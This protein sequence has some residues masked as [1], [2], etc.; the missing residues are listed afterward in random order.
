MPQVYD[1]EGNIFSASEP[2]NVE[3]AVYLGTTVPVYSGSINT[4]LRY[5]NWELAAQFLFEGGHKMRNTNVAALNIDSYYTNMGI[6]PVSKNIENRWKQPG[7]ET[8]T[9]VPRF[10]SSES[11][12]YNYYAYNLY[13]RS[14]VNV[15]N[16]ANWRMKNLSVAYRLPAD[17]CKKLALQEARIMFGMENLFTTAKSRDAK[18]MLGGYDKPNY[19][20]T[21][22]LNF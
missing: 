18:W 13:A 19:L 6:A 16:A 12:D 4:N 9:D 7:D 8:R 1:A 20:C 10:V 15:L 3:D 2:Y 17:L 22:S 11:P 21:V 5:K 14:S